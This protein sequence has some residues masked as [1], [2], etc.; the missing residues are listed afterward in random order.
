MGI[1][2]G[3]VVWAMVGTVACGGRAESNGGGAPKPQPR[4]A[5]VPDAGSVPT[6]DGP[7]ELVMACPSAL[8]SVRLKLPCQ[9]GQSISGGV[10]EM[11]CDLAAT[12]SGVPHL[13]PVSLSV[14]MAQL[15]SMLNTPIQIPFE[16]LPNPAPGGYG[17]I[18]EYPGE[19]FEGTFSGTAVFSRADAVT[20]SFM[21]RLPQ[22]Q[23]VWTGDQGDSFTCTV[24]DEPFWAVA[25]DFL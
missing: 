5:G 8:A 2:K 13:P 10:S 17:T 22:A 1:F 6:T 7:A 12:Q 11:E 16:N 18:P 19:R 9:V 21:A 23:F 20:R 15:G 14:P 25:G 24:T 3:I 4:Q